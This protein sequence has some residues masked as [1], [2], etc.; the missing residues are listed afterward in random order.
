M[1]DM[2][3]VPPYFVFDSGELEIFRSALRLCAHVEAD[4]AESCVV[5]DSAGARLRLVPGL[6]GP[7][8]RISPFDIKMF[9]RLL[10]PRRAV[11]RLQFL[12]S[13]QE[14]RDAFESA[15]R[16]FLSRIGCP[17]KSSSTIEDLVGALLAAWHFT[18]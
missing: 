8:E 4:D 6:S 11:V 1:G 16:D 7:S 12:D 2:I 14:T 13:S 5:F 9:G 15:A 3:G 10:T 17:P 18:D